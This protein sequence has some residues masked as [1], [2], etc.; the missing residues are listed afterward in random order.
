M[1]GKAHNLA[2]SF[3][4]TSEGKIF[5]ICLIILSKHVQRGEKFQET[6]K[7]SAN[8]QEIVTFSR[9]HRWWKGHVCENT[10]FFIYLIM[11]PEHVHR[12]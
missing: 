10:I 3:V 9:F 5:F 8:Q 1:M 6:L 7:V 4:N 11:L 2:D 12:G